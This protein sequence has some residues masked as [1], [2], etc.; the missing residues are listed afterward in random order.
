MAEPDVE[1][2]PQVADPVKEGQ[3]GAQGLRVAAAVR[4]GDQGRGGGAAVRC[5]AVGVPG[6]VHGSA[7]SVPGDEAELCAELVGDAGEKVRGA[8]GQRG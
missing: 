2:G 4:H 6:A 7:G 3:H 5:G 1:A 8:V